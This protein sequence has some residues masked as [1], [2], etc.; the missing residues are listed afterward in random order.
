MSA[1]EAHIGELGGRVAD[2][3]VTPTLTVAGA[4][5]SGDFV[6]TSATPLAFAT[7]VRISGGSGII[8]SAVLVDYA[9]QS[10]PIE[11]WIFNA[12]FTPPADNAA[13]SISDADALKCIAVITFDTWFA[14]ALN[15]VS[16]IGNIGKAFKL[17]G[18][19]ALYGALVTRGA[20]TYATGDLSLTLNI[21]QD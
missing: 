9:K 14:S 11:L 18:V 1:G 4:Y 3:L 13:W 19:T 7:A 12:T 6:G 8:H 21:L 15:S 2:Q 10:I 17:S 16:F 20:P 5:V